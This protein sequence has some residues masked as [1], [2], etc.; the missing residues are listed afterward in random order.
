MTLP[1][2][3]IYQFAVSANTRAYSSGMVWA[4]C[5]ILHNKGTFA[6]DCDRGAGRFPKWMERD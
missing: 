2:T 4:T 5:T 6:G 3:D 1:T